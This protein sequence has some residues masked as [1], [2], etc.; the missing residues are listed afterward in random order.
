[1]YSF[2]EV[3]FSIGPLLWQLQTRAWNRYVYARASTFG[4]KNI[5]E[6]D[7]DP[8]EQ[9]PRIWWTGGLAVSIVVSTVL[10]N[11]LFNMTILQALFSLLIGFLFSFV[12]IQSSGQTDVNPIGTVAKASQVIFGGLTRTAGVAKTSA[13]M[14]NLT[15]GVIAAGSA[16]Q[17][18][19]MVI[20]IRS[21]IH[22]RNLIA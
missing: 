6:E 4:P 2:T 13:Q 19:D 9:V 18:T 17:A 11:N 16:G 5:D 12:G 20:H 8:S 10:L 21:Y 3:A 15:A 22:Q 14:V 7:D 1:V